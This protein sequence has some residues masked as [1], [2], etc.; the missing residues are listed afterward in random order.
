VQHQTI[1]YFQLSILKN[2]KDLAFWSSTSSLLHF[3]KIGERSPGLF[4]SA[5]LYALA[6]VRAVPVCDLR[7]IALDRIAFVA[8]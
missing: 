1:N 2:K 4:T 6:F 7:A 3:S 8:K 5:P